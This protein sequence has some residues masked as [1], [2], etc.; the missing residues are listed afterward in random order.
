MGRHQMRQ[1]LHACMAVVIE[2][3]ASSIFFRGT[4]RVKIFCNQYIPCLLAA[5]GMLVLSLFMFVLLL[6]QTR[7]AP[8][9]VR[10]AM[11]P[12][13]TKNLRFGREANLC[14]NPPLSFI[15]HYFKN[16]RISFSFREV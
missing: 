11:H 3:P 1:R 15:R 12:N 14:G 6:S 8:Q 16:M 5:F 9:D 13:E 4:I 2:G 10:I 7:C